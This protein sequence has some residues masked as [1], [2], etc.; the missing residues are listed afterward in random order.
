MLREFASRIFPPTAG[1]IAL[2]QPGGAASGRVIPIV[3]R[4]RHT[5]KAAAGGEKFLEKTF[6]LIRESFLG[7]RVD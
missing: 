4:G 7:Q 1:N 5:R 2:P 6:H 3:A